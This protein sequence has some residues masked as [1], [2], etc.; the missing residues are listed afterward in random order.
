MFSEILTKLSRKEPLSVDEMDRAMSEILSAKI[1]EQDIILFLTRLRD[2]VETVDEIEGAARALRAKMIRCPV[3]STDFIDVC[4]TGGD[5]QHT[6]NISTAVAFVVAGAGVKVAKHGNRAVSSKSG[7]SDVLTALGVK[8]DVT[9]EVAARCID[10]IGVGF[11]FAPLYHPALKIVAE[12][13]KKIGTRTLF[14]IIGPLVNPANAKKQVV[15]VY[16]DKL[17]E[18]VANV[19][20]KL[21]STNVAVVHGQDGLDEVTLTSLTNITFLNTKGI[22]QKV[23]DPHEVGY[24][25]CTPADLRGG[26]ATENAKRLRRVLKGHSE[27]IDHCVHLN[28]ALA[29]CVAGKAS[30]MKEGI[31]LAQES[32]SSGKA[33]QKLEQLIE[34]TNKT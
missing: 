5:G 21:G 6:F 7:S 16:D 24:N 4:G 33:Y 34:M 8:V 19:L 2:K 31:L 27:A 18:V 1:S 15:G 30:E 22:A 12:A 25:F 13:R 17:R 23:F 10:Q 28:S 26:D 14:N 11:L 29:L 32:I 3:E 20:L 9:P